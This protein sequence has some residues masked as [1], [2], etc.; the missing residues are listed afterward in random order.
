MNE[1]FTATL[2]H[3]E[4]GTDFDEEE[5]MFSSDLPPDFAS[6]SKTLDEALHGSDAKH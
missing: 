1:G 4:N 2:A 3:C 6:D 5:E